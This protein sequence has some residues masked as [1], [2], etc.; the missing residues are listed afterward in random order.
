MWVCWALTSLSV[1]HEKTAGL[2]AALHAPMHSD[3]PA[4]AP[5]LQNTNQTIII[6]IRRGFN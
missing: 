2:E 3:E 6:D 1:M 5:C 4:S